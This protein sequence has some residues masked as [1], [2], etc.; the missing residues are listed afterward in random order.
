MEIYYKI[1]RDQCILDK[2][3]C[4]RQIQI[5]LIHLISF[6]FRLGNIDPSFFTNYYQIVN[7]FRD[8]DFCLKI[9]LLKFLG[10]FNNKRYNFIDEL[11]FA[12]STCEPR[13]IIYS[14][15]LN[16]LN[17]ISIFNEK[18]QKIINDKLTIKDSIIIGDKKFHEKIKTVEKSIKSRSFKYLNIKEVHKYLDLNIKNKDVRISR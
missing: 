6:S 17:K 3:P 14:S 9:Y 15:Y 7:F 13:Y 16:Q 12:L 2:K 5:S 1:M 10:E 18:E 8:I 4:L 11:N